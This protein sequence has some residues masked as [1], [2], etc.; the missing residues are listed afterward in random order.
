MLNISFCSNTSK[1]RA[2]YDITFTLCRLYSCIIP[3]FGFKRNCRR[4]VLV[5]RAEERLLKT[6]PGKDIGRYLHLSCSS[7]VTNQNA[8]DEVTLSTNPKICSSKDP[9]LHHFFDSE[10]FVS[11]NYELKLSDKGVLTSPPSDSHPYLLRNKRLLIAHFKSLTACKTNEHYQVSLEKLEEFKFEINRIGGEPS[12]LLG[13]PTQPRSECS[14]QILRMHSYADLFLSLCFRSLL[15][16]YRGRKLRDNEGDSCIFL[17]ERMGTK[18]VALLI[19]ISYHSC[20]RILTL[21]A[22][23]N[24]YLYNTVT[25]KRSLIYD[26][27]L[28]RR[29]RIQSSRP[30]HELV[31]ASIYKAEDMQLSANRKH[32]IVEE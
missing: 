6:K 19:H 32:F 14:N 2:H 15:L 3:D 8:S 23:Y 27:K 18:S 16:F 26:I 4:A 30:T 9:I 20:K 21:I 12:T 24:L 7:L 31:Q 13:E 25:V 17:D 11:G 5:P 10:N 1:K 22:T 29:G 28:G